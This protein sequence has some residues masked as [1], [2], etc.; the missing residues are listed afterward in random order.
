MFPQNHLEV[1]CDVTK[2]KG[3]E[4]CTEADADSVEY[5]RNR[6][7]KGGQTRRTHKVAN[8]LS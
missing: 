8:G 4:R 3:S 6:T 1:V 5:S 2:T 7:E